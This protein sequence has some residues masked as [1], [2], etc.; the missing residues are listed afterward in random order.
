MSALLQKKVHKNLSYNEVTE[1]TRELPSSSI[2][3]SPYLTPATETRNI[4]KGKKKRFIILSY[5]TKVQKSDIPS[6]RKKAHRP[7][8]S[9]QHLVKLLVDLGQTRSKSLVA[10]DRKK[11]LKAIF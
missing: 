7:T 1:V 4:S 6:T 8:N 2:F 5:A 11:H 10:G 3:V 9:E